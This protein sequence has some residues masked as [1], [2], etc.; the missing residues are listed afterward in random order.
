MPR[1]TLEALASEIGLRNETVRY[2]EGR[3]RYT[4]KV[5]YG[6]N[7]PFA[8][9]SNQAPRFTVTAELTSGREWSGGCL[10]DEVRTRFPHLTPFIRWHLSSTSE[11]MHYVANGVYWY[12]MAHGRG[13]WENTS[14]HDPIKAV[15]S[16]ILY[17]TAPGDERVDLSLDP[18][19]T[20]GLVPV[21]GED[22]VTDAQVEA[23]F[24]AWLAVRFDSMM[25]AFVTDMQT[26]S[27]L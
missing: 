14:N 27:A 18:V 13:R 6:F 25:A 20:F 10:H 4:I 23:A 3:K 24:R 17:G 12:L 5:E 21:E 22:T 11:P 26:L 8:R 1:T 7:L 19:E 15:K 16:T 9:R 2:T